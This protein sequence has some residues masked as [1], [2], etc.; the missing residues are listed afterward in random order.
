MN[1]P[2][3]AQLISAF[4]GSI[5]GAAIGAAV[6]AYAGKRAERLAIKHDLDKIADEVRTVTN[7][8]ESIRAVISNQYWRRQEVW[9]QKRQ[10]YASLILAMDELADAY[11][12][13][14]IELCE[15][16][17]AG[18]ELGAKL[19]KNYGTVRQRLSVARLFADW[20]IEGVWEAAE[21]KLHKLISG[22]MPRELH[23]EM[24]EY[25]RKESKRLVGEFRRDLGIDGSGEAN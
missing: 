19:H 5:F 20:D 9:S 23:W 15:A 12:E 3:W 8:T 4:F 24:E 7:Q 14:A 13:V 2:N 17:S 6:G 16:P 25:W 21:Q 10:Q 22:G 11:Q 1:E 18:E